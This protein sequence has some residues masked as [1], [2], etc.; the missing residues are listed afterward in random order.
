MQAYAH[1]VLLAPPHL[2]DPLQSLLANAWRATTDPDP[3]AKQYAPRVLRI[4]RILP[5]Q[6]NPLY[7]LLA[8]SAPPITMGMVS[9]ARHVLT[10]V[11]LLVL[12]AEL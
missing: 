2:L 9:C 8:S 12:Q 7:L 1:L 5:K 3:A 6:Q 11:I 4:V 10:E